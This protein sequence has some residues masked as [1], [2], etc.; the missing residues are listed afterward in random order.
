MA[1]LAEASTE[2]AR[3]GVIDHQIEVLNSM[4][5]RMRGVTARL[6]EL[7]DALTGRIVPVETAIDK[8]APEPQPS[9]LLARLGEAESITYSA[10][11]DLESAVEKLNG[12]GLV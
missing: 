11:N 4:E 7:C 2:V 10:I 3:Q 12:I 9:T 8:A 6:N 5:G 1:G